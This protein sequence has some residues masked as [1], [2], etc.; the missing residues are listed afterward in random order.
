MSLFDMALSL[1][2]C[3]F[4][5]A[6]P[7]RPIYKP[8]RKAK[9]IRQRNVTFD[10]RAP[11]LEVSDNF[12]RR[13]EKSLPPTSNKQFAQY[14]AKLDAL[15]TDKN[16]LVEGTDPPSSLTLAFAR[17]ILRQLETEAL[18][19][20]RVVASA[21]GGVAICFVHGSKYS[22]IECLNSGEIL[23]VISNRRDHP[24]AW[25]V[26]PSAGGIAQATA[27]IRDFIGGTPISNDAKR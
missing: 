2:A 24:F 17:A 5:D 3:Y 25:E 10:E 21:E 6:P 23:G 7:R 4:E 15:G 27:R 9:I 14:F 1:D 18:E 8:K 12:L 20:D 11:A 19:P 22:D 26:D 13:L 16:L